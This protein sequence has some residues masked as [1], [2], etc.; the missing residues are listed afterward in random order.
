[1]VAWKYVSGKIYWREYISKR[2]DRCNLSKKYHTNNLLKFIAHTRWQN[3]KRRKLR[4]QKT[5][6]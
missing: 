3:H 2:K 1:M 6:P 4:G 5:A